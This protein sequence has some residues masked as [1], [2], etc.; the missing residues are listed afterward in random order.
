MVR[1]QHGPQP[2]HMPRV[3]VVLIVVS[4]LE[5]TRL[6]AAEY[7]GPS[8]MVSPAGAEGRGHRH[9][10]NLLQSRFASQ[11]MPASTAQSLA[12]GERAAA[13]P[14]LEQFVEKNRMEANEQLVQQ[15]LHQLLDRTRK[16]FG[17]DDVNDDVGQ[18]S[19]DAVTDFTRKAMSAAETT[20]RAEEHL[21]SN[22]TAKAHSM[23]NLTSQSANE[24]TSFSNFS[25][26]VTSGVNS[27]SN[28]SSEL[29]MEVNSMSNSSSEMATGVESI[30]NLSSELATEVNSTSNLVDSLRVED[31]TGSSI[32]R[33][34][35]AREEMLDRTVSNLTD[36][37]QLVS[38]LTDAAA[39]NASESAWSSSKPMSW[40]KYVY[41]KI[42]GLG[43]D[44]LLWVLV[45]MVVAKIMSW[46]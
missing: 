19:E 24:V 4:A 34:D 43:N 30:S 8:C 5:P 3:S 44:A 35:T 38:N 6:A 28:L 15:P 36:L 16:L 32:G 26:V 2:Q 46:A 13:D 1:I 12:A 33:V 29:A 17:G 9:C 20:A 27:T 42:V 11:E 22:S 14:H 31:G 37:D 23:G 21:G 10:L 45:F 25:S 40:G 7:S 39:S 18:S 41:T